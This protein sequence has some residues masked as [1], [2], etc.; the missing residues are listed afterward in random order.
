MI[1]IVRTQRPVGQGGFHT[2]QAISASGNSYTWIFDC[3]STRRVQIEDGVTDWCAQH[4]NVDCLFIS[5]FEADHANGIEKLLKCAAVQDV[6]LPYVGLY[7]LAITLIE[8]ALNGRSED[9]FVDLVEDPA[10][11]FLNRG[12]GRVTCRGFGGASTPRGRNRRHSRCHFRCGVEVTAS[13][14]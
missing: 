10:G 11:Y 6:M 8:A 5:H 14:R 2:G 7:D 12:A 4:S 13:Q 3:S 1:G 9:W